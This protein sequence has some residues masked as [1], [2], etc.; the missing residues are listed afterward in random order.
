[1]GYRPTPVAASLISDITLTLV[2]QFLFTVAGLVLLLLRIEDTAVVW[3]VIFGLLAFL[4]MVAGLFAIQ[5]MGIVNMGAKLVGALFGDRW[6]DLVGNAARLD[7]VLRLVYRRPGRVLSS[8]GWQLIGWT[9]GTGEIYLALQFMD[10]PVDL[11]DAV[12]LE[13]LAQAI[14]SAAF[15]VP[16]AVGVQEGGFIL[17]GAMLGL[18]PGTALAVAIARRIR[19][20]I[21]FLPGLITWQ[22]AEAHKLVTRRQPAE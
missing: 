6:A 22:I 13:S 9:V 12:L 2:S 11:Y 7:R 3:R 16:G 18:D 21:I 14:S 17:L 8:I 4:P 1:M 20:A 10:H 15:V 5:R 19:D